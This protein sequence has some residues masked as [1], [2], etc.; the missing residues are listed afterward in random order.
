MSLVIEK[1]Y[2]QAP[3]NVDVRA[4]YGSV[5]ACLRKISAGKDRYCGG[6]STASSALETSCI[7]G[8][9][10]PE[11]RE[12]R[13]YDVDIRIEVRFVKGTKRAGIEDAYLE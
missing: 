13:R 3:R 4:S 8:D 1:Y 6:C 2:K 7:P 5:L 10:K 11:R 9:R 12:S